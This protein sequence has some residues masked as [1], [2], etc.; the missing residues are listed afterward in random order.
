MRKP[1]FDIVDRL[2]SKAAPQRAAVPARILPAVDARSGSP[3]AAPGPPFPLDMESI[4]CSRVPP[5]PTAAQR[6][7]WRPPLACWTTCHQPHAKRSLLP[8][9]T[10][11]PTIMA[12]A[13]RA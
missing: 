11:Q 6:P 1:L 4:A 8:Q 3:E 2:Q 7:Q 12:L 5:N 9:D 13:S 10:G